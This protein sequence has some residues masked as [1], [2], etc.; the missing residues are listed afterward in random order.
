V[1]IKNVVGIK[2][3]ALT[4]Q[5]VRLLKRYCENLLLSLDSDAAGDMASRRGIEIADKAGFNIKI[6]TL[7]K[8]K[9]PDEA[10]QKDPQYLKIRLKEAE[11]VYDFY[12]NSAFNRFRG[13]T[14]EEK[15]KIGQELLP[16][17]A[18]I[19]DEIVKDVYLKK[20]SRKLGVNEESLIFQIDKLTKNI[21]VPKKA[22]EAVPDKGKRD[23]LEDYYLSLIF[24]G[25]KAK[26]VFEEEN[27]LI[28]LPVNKK[29]L[30]ALRKYFE[31]NKEFSSQFFHKYLPPELKDAFDR[32]YL[33][34]FSE[35][36]DD[37]D[38]LK[39]ELGNIRRLLQVLST[40]EEMR[41]LIGKIRLVSEEESLPLREKAGILAKKLDK[42]EKR[43]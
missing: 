35:K 10:A 14:A 40:R 20:L 16:I 34:D 33:T 32:F 38:W 2:G 31:E 6:V 36:I 39:K 22:E 25:K 42:L 4:E 43:A 23:V 17:L 5:Q 3:S 8:F 19:D 13:S 26:L 12:I 21:I 41:D 37:I 18:K 7:E 30:E 11:N 29:I 15:K 1:G 24:Q 28:K 27:D 9:D